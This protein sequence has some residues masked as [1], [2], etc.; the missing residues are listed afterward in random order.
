MITNLPQ[1]ATI[2]PVAPED[3][4][5]LA[6]L[7]RAVMTEFGACGP[8]FSIMDPE[9]D[10]MHRAYQTLGHAYFVLADDQSK[11]WAGAGIAPLTGSDDPTLCELRKMYAL[12]QAR[13]AGYGRQLL[14]RC[15]EAARAS[16]YTRCY[17]ETLETMASAA[18]LYQRAG[19]KALDAPLGQTGH[20][21]CDR[22]YLLTL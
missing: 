6:A 15:L 13:G 12:P 18:A 4:P 2:R 10:H 16:G 22:Y 9:V 20:S 11:I 19:F 8:G 5:Q 1:S 7:I 14:D 21:G 17:L 3:E